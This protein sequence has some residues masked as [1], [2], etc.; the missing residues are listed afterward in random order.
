MLSIKCAEQTASGYKSYPAAELRDTGMQG[1]LHN[2]VL[3][4]LAHL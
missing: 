4:L 2:M 1:S 3:A